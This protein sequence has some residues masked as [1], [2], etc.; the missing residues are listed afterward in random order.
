MI[1]KKELDNRITDLEDSIERKIDVQIHLINRILDLE[2]KVEKLTARMNHKAV[3][4]QAKKAKQTAKKSV[5]K[6]SKKPQKIGVKT[7]TVRMKVAPIEKTLCCR[8]E[9]ALEKAIK[10]QK[11]DGFKVEKKSVNK[12]GQHIAILK[13]K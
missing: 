13:Q 6:T 1:S 3:K 4:P 10:K 12:K 11:E 2:E 7:A 5:R 8:T 9:D